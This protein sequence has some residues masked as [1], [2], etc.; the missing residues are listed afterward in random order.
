METGSL[1]DELLKL[2]DLSLETSITSAFIQARGKIK[3]DAFKLLFNHFNEKIHKNMLYHGYRLLDIDDSE[4]S[5]DNT[6]YDE[7]IT[8]LR[9]GTHVKS[10]SAII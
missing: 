4:L 9:F 2:N 1:K 7:E 6:I 3:I 10:Y 8:E 5:I